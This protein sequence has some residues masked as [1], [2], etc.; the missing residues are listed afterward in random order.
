MLDLLRSNCGI[1][2]TDTPESMTAKVRSGL[3]RVGIDPD[4]DSPVLLHVLGVKDTLPCRPLP[5]L[6]PSRRR[7]SKSSAKSA[8]N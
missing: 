3:E 2:E 5:I 8:S 7:P 6:R 4:Q 1:L